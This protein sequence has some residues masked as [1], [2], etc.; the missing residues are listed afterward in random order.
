[1]ELHSCLNVCVV[2]DLELGGLSMFND[3][4]KGLKPQCETPTWEQPLLN[5]KEDDI[6]DA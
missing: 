3:L 6:D 4:V 5:H 2:A 1:M